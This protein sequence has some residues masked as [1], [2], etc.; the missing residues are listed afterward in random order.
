MGASCR[1]DVAQSQASLQLRKAEAIT[2]AV[3]ATRQQLIP[4]IEQQEKEAA[5][6]KQEAQK[7]QVCCAIMCCIGCMGNVVVFAVQ[8]LFVV[9]FVGQYTVCLL[10]WLNLSELTARCMQPGHSPCNN[11]ST[12]GSEISRQRWLHLLLL[13]GFEAVLQATVTCVVGWKALPDARSV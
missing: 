9:V 11:C 5:A 1:Q 7:A 12:Q 8:L 4:I 13:I 6:R 10:A 3:Q 2:K